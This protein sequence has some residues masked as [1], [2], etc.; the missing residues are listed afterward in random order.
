[1]RDDVRKRRACEE[2]EATLGVADGGSGR[3]REEPEEEVE[4]VHEEFADE[5]TLRL[6]KGG[7]SVE[8]GSASIPAP[9]FLWGGEGLVCREEG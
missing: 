9:S 3:R 6:G 1:M 5:G 8:S 4:G 2:L 7:V